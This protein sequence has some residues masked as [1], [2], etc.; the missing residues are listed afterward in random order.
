MRGQ[1]GPGRPDGLRIEPAE[2]VRADVDDEEAQLAFCRSAV[3]SVI[4]MLRRPSTFHPCIERAEPNCLSLYVKVTYSR[5]MTTRQ[6]ETKSGRWTLRVTSTQDEAVRRVLAETGE[7]L[8]EYVVR[9]AV[10]AA[11]QDLADRRAFALDDAGWNE[12]QALL[13]RPPV[14]KPHLSKLMSNPSVLE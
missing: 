6:P 14:Y 11:H 4:D 1:H 7:S 2:Y 3:L 9:H 10:L 8:N 13:D 5:D 12:L